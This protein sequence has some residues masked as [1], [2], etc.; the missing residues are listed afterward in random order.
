MSRLTPSHEVQPVMSV[1]PNSSALNLKKETFAVKEKL[2]YVSHTNDIQEPILEE[3]EHPGFS[4]GNLAQETDLGF[5]PAGT[6]HIWLNG[7]QP[8]EIEP[9]N[10]DP[11]IHQFGY[12]DESSSRLVGFNALLLHQN[13][14][15]DDHFPNNS[16][17]GSNWHLRGADNTKA[18]TNDNEMPSD[19]AGERESLSLSELSSTERD[20]EA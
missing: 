6:Y 19:Q 17:Y 11:E 13:G 16:I 20:N 3:Q 18:F 9:K 12:E 1:S 14:N 5:Q 2:S 10:L 8:N 7:P 15:F 4:Q